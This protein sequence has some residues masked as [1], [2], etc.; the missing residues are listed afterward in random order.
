MKQLLI[1]LYMGEQ[2][3]YLK[4]VIVFLIGP[5]NAQLSYLLLAVMIDVIFGM[6]VASKNKE[7]SIVLLFSKVRK[8]LFVYAL[9]ISMFHA[10]DMVTGLPNTARWSVI[11]MLLGMEL[12]SA[13]KNT[14]KLGHGRLSDALEH[15]YLS[16]IKTNAG[17]QKPEKK[18]VSPE[19]VLPVGQE[20]EGS[21][22][23]RTQKGSK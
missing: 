9:W 5:I 15:V 14:A 23:D 7:F 8:K 13:A 18:A 20:G 22:E 3:L 21:N 11:V 2:F 6:Q 12:L 16:L 19:T 10:F 17:L 1:N 4:G